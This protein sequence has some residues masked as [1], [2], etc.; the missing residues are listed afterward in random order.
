[1]N[2]IHVLIWCMANALL[3]SSHRHWLALFSHRIDAVYIHIFLPRHGRRAVITTFV[4][5][6]NIWTIQ[7]FSEATQFHG[8]R[9][10]MGENQCL[11]IKTNICEWINELDTYSS[12]VLLT[13]KAIDYCISRGHAHVPLFVV[14]G[15]IKYYNVLP[16]FEK[17]QLS[18]DC[19][20]VI[21]ELR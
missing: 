2:G 6:V 7:L 3:Y 12:P 11:K 10:F 4:H 1:M 5:A 21:Q 18:I 17:S 19:M 13:A 16:T 20:R 8:K 14:K 15:E 9:N